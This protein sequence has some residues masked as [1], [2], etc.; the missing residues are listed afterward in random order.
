LQRI[1]PGI[2]KYIEKMAEKTKRNKI[3]GQCEALYYY[4]KE[5]GVEGGGGGILLKNTRY[6]PFIVM[7]RTN[8]GIKRKRVK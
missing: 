6:C 5:E 2:E 4:W 7:L 1:E 8:I 3:Q